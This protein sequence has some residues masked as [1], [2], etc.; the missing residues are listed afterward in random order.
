MKTAE[1]VD[2]ELVKSK[3]DDILNLMKEELP[4]NT[5]MKPRIC[6]RITLTT[7]KNTKKI[8]SA[9]LKAIRGKFGEAVDSG[10][11]SE[12]GHMVLF[13]YELC[14]IWGGSPATQQVETGIESSDINLVEMDDPGPLSINSGTSGNGEAD[15]ESLATEVSVESTEEQSSDG[16]ETVRQRKEYLDAK[17]KSEKMKQK[18]PV[19]FQLLA[20]A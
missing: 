10:Q 3:Y 6:V 18:L 13:L 2:R 15:W 1:N 19:D 11:R 9:K 17:L 12:H 4:A 5:L 8:L 7:K 14:E 20:C 16:Q